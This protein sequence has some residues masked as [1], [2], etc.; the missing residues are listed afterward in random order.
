M[1][2]NIWGKRFESRQEYLLLVSLATVKSSL[3]RKGKIKLYLVTSVKNHARFINWQ[4]SK[5]CRVCCIAIC[6]LS[7]D[8]K[9][10]ETLKKLHSIVFFSHAIKY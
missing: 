7:L 3:D 1:L 8:D 5:L 9:K 10:C 6:S 4:N 2:Y